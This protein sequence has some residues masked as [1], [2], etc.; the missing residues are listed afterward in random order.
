MSWSMRERAITSDLVLLLLLAFSLRVIWVFL[1]PP[2]QAPDEPAHF[3]Y[4]AHIGEQCEP[5]TYWS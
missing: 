1:I 4:I 5:C 2:W 3:A